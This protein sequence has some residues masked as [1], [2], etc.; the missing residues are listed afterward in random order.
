MVSTAQLQ[1]K[2]LTLTIKQWDIR[3]GERDRDLEGKI[4]WKRDRSLSKNSDTNRL[5][6]ERQKMKGTIVYHEKARHGEKMKDGE[7]W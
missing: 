5:M 6:E 3:N 7:E 1:A 2:K 4:I